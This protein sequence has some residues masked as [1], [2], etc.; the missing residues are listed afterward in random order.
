MIVWLCR[1]VCVCVLDLIPHCSS[2]PDCSLGSWGAR[3]VPVVG[4]GRKHGWYSSHWTPASPP[5]YHNQSSSG[6]KGQREKQ[7]LYTGAQTEHS[8]SRASRSLSLNSFLL[9]PRWINKDFIDFIKLLVFIFVIIQS[10]ENQNDGNH[11]GQ[12]VLECVGDL[13]MWGVR[14]IILSSTI[15][16]YFEFMRGPCCCNTVV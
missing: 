5:S 7:T 11:K 15:C 13:I 12:F 8:C 4:T 10:G 6:L 9:Q 16:Q 1:C 2:C 14:S 3:V